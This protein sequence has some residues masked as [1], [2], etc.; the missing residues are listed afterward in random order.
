M[1]D[2]HTFMAG[3]HFRQKGSFR[4][5]ETAGLDAPLLMAHIFESLGGKIACNT[6]VDYVQ[7]AL[8][9]S[10]ILVMRV[11]LARRAASIWPAL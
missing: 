7:C 9:M 10:R 11:K 2:A 6:A 5:L 3:A 4:D 8:R 1:L